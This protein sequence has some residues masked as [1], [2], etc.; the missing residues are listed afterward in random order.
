DDFVA[1]ANHAQKVLDGRGDDDDHRQGE[2]GRDQVAVRPVGGRVVGGLRKDG[3]GGRGH[4]AGGSGLFLLLTG[5]PLLG[6]AFV[7]RHGRV[8]GGLVGGRFFGGRHDGKGGHEQH[9]DDGGER[10][11]TTDHWHIGEHY[12]RLPS[13]PNLSGTGT[14][15][16]R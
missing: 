4:R 13:G 2:E 10:E 12:Q 9:Q 6:G 3:D 11:E 1:V 14:L 7:A 5:G 15:R 16:P 8:G